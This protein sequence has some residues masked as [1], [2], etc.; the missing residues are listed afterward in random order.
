MAEP[1]IPT[2]DL[3]P[4]TKNDEDGKKKAMEVITKACSEYGFF[5]IVN[6]GV[7]I[8]LLQRALDLSK[9]FFEYPSDEKLKSS[10]ASNAPLPAGYNTQPQ[11]SPD[12]NE[13]LL[14]FPPGSTFNVFPQNP[15]DFK[16]VL[17]DVFSKLT[18]TGLL[19]ETI[20][21]QCL[22][23][24]PNFLKEYNH[25][26][27]WDF[28]VAL[29]YFPATESENNGLTEHEDSNCIS[30]VFQ[31]EAG[32]LEVSK[33]GE[34]IPV[35]PAKGTLV[36]NISDVIQ[37]LSNNKFKSATH[38]VVRPKGRSRYSFAFFYN[39]QGDKW[40][41]PLPHFT[42]D[43]GESPKY[44]GFQYSEYLQLRLR[45]KTH[46]PTTPEDE[47]RITHYTITS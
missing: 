15:P 11:Q 35:I 36:V 28:M 22:G 34:W 44:R 18:E 16:R 38:R 42:K 39:L 45:N 5:Q 24:P 43:I 9:V 21:N 40:V 12:K 33:D 8:N 23:L 20:V 17:E 41:E 47:I 46:P 37:V 7:P 1:L 30:L 31:D 14:M 29:R 3:S 27:S 25:D 6:H 19:V 4:F 32:G 10:P 26:R 13:Y 2:V